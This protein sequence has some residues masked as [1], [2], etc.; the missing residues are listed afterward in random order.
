MCSRQFRDEVASKGG[1][2]Q[3]LNCGAT[4][5][6]LT[7]GSQQPQSNLDAAFDPAQLFTRAWWAQETEHKQKWVPVS[8]FRESVR[9]DTQIGHWG[10]RSLLST[11]KELVHRQLNLD[12]VTWGS[13]GRDLSHS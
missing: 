4:L 5:L 7:A 1:A 9:S 2:L 10:G 8:V 6:S 12:T 3:V 11:L 13:A